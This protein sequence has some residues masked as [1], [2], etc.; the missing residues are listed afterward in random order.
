MCS[1]F[2]SDPVS[3]LSTQM[4]RWP[5]RKSSS[6]RCEPKKPAPPVTR[7]VDMTPNVSAEVDHSCS[8]RGAG[9]SGIRF[10]RHGFH[11]HPRDGRPD[12]ARLSLRVKYALDRVLGGVGSDPSRFPTAL[13]RRPATAGPARP[14]RL[15]HGKHLTGACRARL[16]DPIG[17]RSVRGGRAHHDW[18]EAR[19]RHRHGLY[20]RI[21]RIRRDDLAARRARGDY[22]GGPGH[23][24]L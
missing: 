14:C 2:T 15:L 17:S 19:K 18:C 16:G 7:E 12:T 22:R 9:S 23:R 6:Q 4:T 1:M 24:W 21:L 5:R 3:K 10:A 8:P 13:P 20:R 11:G